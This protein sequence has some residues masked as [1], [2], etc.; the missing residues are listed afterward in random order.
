MTDKRVKKKILVNKSLVPGTSFLN[1]IY[2]SFHL[3]ALLLFA[4][5]GRAQQLVFNGNFEDVNICDE[6]HAPCSPS[7]W[8]Y[9]NKTG[10][11]GYSRQGE[12]GAKEQN[13]YLRMLVARYD[14]LTRQYWETSLGAKMESGK[15]YKASFK[16][17]DE[18]GPNLN[19]I[20]FY[21]CNSFILSWQ[22]S[23]LQPENYISFA[24]VNRKN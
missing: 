12:L 11:V 22:D 4:Q 17:Y 7:A 24:D 10:S 3:I 15:R 1:R 5:S 2:K 16:I 8:F 6:F 18:N 20:G 23:L 19:D 21:F 9:M 13:R 14:T